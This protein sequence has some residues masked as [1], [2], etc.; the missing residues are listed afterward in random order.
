MSDVW[1][2]VLRSSSTDLVRRFVTH[3]SYGIKEGGL[4]GH[5]QAFLVINN[6]CSCF[7]MQ[8]KDTTPVTVCHKPAKHF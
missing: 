1:T 5:A 8:K 6:I 4:L 2:G 7:P 3:Q